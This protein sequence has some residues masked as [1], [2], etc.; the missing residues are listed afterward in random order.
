MS[1][2]LFLLAGTWW[3][4]SVTDSTDPCIAGTV[5]V[6]SLGPTRALVMTEWWWFLT[7]HTDTYAL[8]WPQNHSQ[9]NESWCPCTAFFSQDT[10]QPQ[11]KQLCRYKVQKAWTLNKNE[12]VRRIIWIQLKR[13]FAQ[14]SSN[15]FHAEQKNV[16][17]TRT[18]NTIITSTNVE[19]QTVVC[20]GLTYSGL[21]TTRCGQQ[22]RWWWLRP[23][24]EI[25]AL[26]KH[27]HSPGPR[28]WD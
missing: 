10:I 21:I 6:C 17:G 22:V 7:V 1:K 4:L 24:V 20:A 13:L 25:T 14:M 3:S 9:T 8:G 26:W 18:T 23:G 19:Q 16:K 27:H 5:W 11:L 28:P 12:K 2:T 15:I